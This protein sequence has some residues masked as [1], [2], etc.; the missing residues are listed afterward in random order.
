[1]ANS[2]VNLGAT[3]NAGWQFTNFSGAANGATVTMDSPKSVTANFTP[4]PTAL[5]LSIVAKADL[6]GLRQWTLRVTN[7]GSGP[8]VNA[9]LNSIAITPI[10]PASIS[11]ATQLPLP[12]GNIVPGVSVL[13]PVSFNWPLSTPLTRAR[14]TFSLSGDYNHASSMTLN[15]L[16]R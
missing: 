13:V 15:N 12:L 2:I 8:V 7:I 1:V 14:M 6:G 10:G 16:F 11:L 5:T 3:P 4:Y 9:S